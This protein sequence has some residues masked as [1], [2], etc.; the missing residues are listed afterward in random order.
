[1]IYTLQEVKAIGEKLKMT[2]QNIRK[3]MTFFFNFFSYQSEIFNNV[4]SRFSRTLNRS[5]PALQLKKKIKM[6]IPTRTTATVVLYDTYGIGFSIGIFSFFFLLL[7]SSN[8]SDAF[9]W[10]S[11]GP[12]YF[13]VYTHDTRTAGIF[14]RGTHRQRQKQFCCSET[15]I[16]VIC[17]YYRYNTY[18]LRPWRQRW[19]TKRESSV[20]QK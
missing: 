13:I 10:I 17:Y 12:T 3:K 4:P 1:M 5:R 18:V 20:F 19:T 14:D 2:R 16:T 11:P 7:F 8:F 9:V 6:P 15:R